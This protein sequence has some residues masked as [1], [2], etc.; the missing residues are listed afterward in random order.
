MHPPWQTCRER[1]YAIGSSIRLPNFEQDILKTNEPILMQLG[2]SGTT[3]K[4]M[5]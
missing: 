3:G 1:H 5:N 4:G 2:T